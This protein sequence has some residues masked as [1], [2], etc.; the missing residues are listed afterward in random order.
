MPK[1]ESTKNLRELLEA[2][3]EIIKE[4]R[5]AKG[6][7]YER[8][9]EDSIGIALSGGGIRSATVCLGI[10]EQFN[11]VGLIKKADYLSSVSGGGY[12]ASYIHA[13]LNGKSAKE[14]EQ[15][16]S[17]EDIEHIRSYRRYLMLLPRYS[18]GTNFTGWYR[19]DNKLVRVFNAIF[20]L[21]NY[22]FL[23]L[24]GIIAILFSWLWL[25]VP[26]WLYVR[27]SNGFWEFSSGEMI[28]YL[29]LPFLLLVFFGH[30]FSP[31]RFSPHW[32]YKWRLSRAYLKEHSALLLKDLQNKQAPYPI[33][34]TAVNIDYDYDQSE[35]IAYRG[36]INSNYF[37]LSPDYCGSQVTCYTDTDNSHFKDLT[38]S[39]AMATSAAAVNTFMGNYKLPLIARAAMVMVNW[40]T[41]ILAANPRVKWNRFVFWPFYAY[42]ELL[43]VADTD[44]NRIQLSDGGHIE[45]LAVYELL[46]RRV[47]TIIAVD[48]GEDST[49]NF[50]DLRNLVIRAR[51]ELGAIITFAD[52]DNPTDVLAPDWATGLSKKNFVV[53]TIRG[54]AGSYAEN[55]KGCLVFIKST[56]L[57]E[58]EFPIRN[59]KKKAKGL[60]ERPKS[61]MQAQIDLSQAKDDLNREMYRTY[62]PKFPHESTSDQFFDK[63]QWDAY[64]ELGGKIGERVLEDIGIESQDNGKSIFIKAS[65]CYS[66]VIK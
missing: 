31:N 46:R 11:R 60:G 21:F 49:F 52:N 43:G 42:N 41:G 13:S 51:N 2:E 29:L 26:S 24:V 16:F 56:I 37:L 1:N 3:A 28:Q 10:M 23:L 12:L 45:N 38:L 27:Y 8:L 5:K 59:L 47:K 64:Y 6:L 25:I 39:T 54:I 62:T 30:L 18:R 66:T 65:N 61:D 33:I 55:Y 9:E 58:E 50:Y 22:L 7:P 32:F 4:R 36:R 15:L 53:A 17:E 40:R 35:D 63:G 57:S 48:A 14:Y 44:T 34:N 20:T 19:L